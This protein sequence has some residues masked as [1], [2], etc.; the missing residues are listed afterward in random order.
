MN[1]ESEQKQQQ[2]TGI[3]KYKNMKGKNSVDVGEFDTREAIRKEK[4]LEK[5]CT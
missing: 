3:H 1:K 5:N 2:Q 4:R